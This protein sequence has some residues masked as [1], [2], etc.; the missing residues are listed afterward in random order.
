MGNGKL[1]TFNNVNENDKELLKKINIE[2]ETI[3]EEV[4]DNFYH[5]IEDFVKSI[6]GEKE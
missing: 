6:Q 3:T 1:K 5:H 4:S 2:I